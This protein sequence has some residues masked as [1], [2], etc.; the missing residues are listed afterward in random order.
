M[1]L[2]PLTLCLPVL[3]QTSFSDTVKLLPGDYYVRFVLRC[4]R[5]PHVCAKSCVSE[6]KGKIKRRNVQES[7]VKGLF[8]SLSLHLLTLEL[9]NG[10][11][12]K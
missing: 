1:T 3:R 9:A 10:R 5:A 8:G 7:E 11:A 12:T 2:D 6:K 4:L